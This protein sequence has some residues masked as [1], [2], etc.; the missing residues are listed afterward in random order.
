MARQEINFT[1]AAIDNLQAPAPG[2]RLEVYDTKT[3][4]LRLR[5]SHT[6]RK[7]FEIYRWHQG[8]P[9]RLKICVWPEKTIEQVRKAAEKLNA[10]FANGE[11]PAE[12][13][14][15]V[16]EE[17]TFSALFHLWLEQFAKPHKR[18]WEDDERRFQN[19]MERPFGNKRLS[20]FTA[21][22]V[23][24]WHQRLTTQQKQRG[25]AATI[26]PATANRSLALLKTV[27]AE[28]APDLHNPC[29]GVK[30]FKETSRE[31]F[32]QPD[33]MKR[34]FDALESEETGETF[35]DYI[36]LSLFTAARRSNVLAMRWTD[37]DL[38]VKLWTIP[39]EVSKNGATMRVPLADAAIEVLERRRR[40]ASSVFVFPSSGSKT[41]HYCTPTKSWKALLQRAKLH[42]LRLHD[43]RRSCGSVMANQGTSIAI[44]GGALGHKHHSSTAVYARLQVS[45]VRDAMEAATRAMLATRE[46][47]EKVI[48][49]RRKAGGE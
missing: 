40:T 38:D 1:K 14:R 6:G 10:E 49:F 18:S 37:L 9:V 19:Y 17:M 3:P 31:R 33:E 2:S 34:L 13:K 48:P 41:G 24:E 21:T 35:R 5:V 15:A 25:P 29:A 44:I 32:L 28:A 46:L 43:L 7:V 39:G 27:F 8:A 22:R 42:D 45:T 12:Q 36:Y 26:A 4:H 30:M 20:W 47:P 16:R 23:R 11:N